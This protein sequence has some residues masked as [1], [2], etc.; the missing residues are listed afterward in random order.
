M[1]NRRA[2][3]GTLILTIATALAIALM[4]SGPAVRIV[5][6]QFVGASQVPGF[7]SGAANAAPPTAI[8]SALAVTNPASNFLILVQGGPVFANGAQFE[9]GQSTIQLA[10]S[11]TYLIVANTAQQTV[12]AKT[13][14]TGPGS[15]TGAANA[16]NPATVLAAIPGLE[17]PIA[18]VVCGNTNCGNTSNGT[19]TDARPLANFPGAGHPLNT[20]PFASLVTTNVSDGTVIYVTGATVLT[21]GSAT[22]TSGAGAALAVRVSG[23]WRCF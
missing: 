23:A 3:F 11:T 2:A 18:T 22:C 16:G 20:V 1:L 13:A 5:H 9:I 19:I 6:A 10:A 14:V 17:V 4:P 15:G 8:G 7:A 21:A 12:Y